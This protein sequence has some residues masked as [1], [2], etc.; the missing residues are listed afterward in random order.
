MRRTGETTTNVPEM[1]LQCTSYL[2]PLEGFYIPNLCRKYYCITVGMYKYTPL[3]PGLPSPTGFRCH[4]FDPDS[5]P[6]TLTDTQSL[7][8]EGSTLCVV[9]QSYCINSRLTFTTQIIVYLFTQ[10]FSFRIQQVSHFQDPMIP[11][12]FVILIGIL[13]QYVVKRNILD[14]DVSDLTSF[15]FGLSDLC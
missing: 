14:P 5:D 12:Q 10:V 4:I 3:T 15:F 8:V 9:V 11:V 13:F 7:V 1:N 6:F 2:L